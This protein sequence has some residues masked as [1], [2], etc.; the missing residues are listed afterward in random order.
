MND[1]SNNISKEKNAFIIQQQQQ[2]HNNN[3]KEGVDHSVL[4][5]IQEHY[6]LSH[7]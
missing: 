6:L 4:A 1:K 7:G 5:N 3:N 2:Q